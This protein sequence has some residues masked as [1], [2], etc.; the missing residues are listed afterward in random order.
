MSFKKYEE[1]FDCEIA[2]KPYTQNEIFESL[3]PKIFSRLDKFPKNEC[4]LRIFGEIF[5]K[6]NRNKCKIIYKDKEYE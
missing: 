3:K 6:N 2:Y 1:N 5:V 4:L